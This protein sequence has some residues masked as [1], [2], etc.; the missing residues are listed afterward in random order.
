MMRR[1]PSLVATII[2]KSDAAGSADLNEYL[3]ER[4]GQSVFEA[5]VY[6]NN[7]PENRV[8]LRWTGSKC[9]P[10]YALPSVT[11]RLVAG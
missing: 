9:L 11:E 2:G 6:T 7:V 3:A 4:R 5:L 8:G 10:D 1:T